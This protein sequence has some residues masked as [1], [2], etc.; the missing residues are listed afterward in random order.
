MKLFMRSLFLAGAVFLNAVGGGVQA[1]EGNYKV[2][3]VFLFKFFKNI[4]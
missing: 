1:E 2:K 3:A 4:N